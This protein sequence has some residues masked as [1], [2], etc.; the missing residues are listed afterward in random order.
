MHLFSQTFEL[1][2]ADYYGPREKLLEWM[3]EQANTNDYACTLVWAA[4]HYSTDSGSKGQLFGSNDGQGYVFPYDGDGS[5]AL[6]EQY[7]YM[8]AKV[9]RATQECMR[10]SLHGIRVS[11]EFQ[12]TAS[13]TIEN[14]AN[15]GVP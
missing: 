6:L 7:N 8:A 11:R 12:P 2:P 10:R 13:C 5:Q 3:H 4:A 9:W 15:P 1:S 14:L